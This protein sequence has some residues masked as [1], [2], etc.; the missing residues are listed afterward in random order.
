MLGLELCIAATVN[1]K[2]IVMSPL[3]PDNT[4]KSH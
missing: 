3:T 1:R 2:L 4:K